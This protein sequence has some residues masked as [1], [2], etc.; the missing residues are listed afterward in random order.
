MLP[1]TTETVDSEIA[2]LQ[3]QNRAKSEEQPT[4]LAPGRL[5]MQREYFIKT[6]SIVGIIL[7]VVGI[8]SL[9][10]YVDPIRLMLRD[11][12]PHKTNPVPRILAGLAL[13]GGIALLYA[14]RGRD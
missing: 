10:Y 3:D 4:K 2:K 8:V 13:A 12:E 11:F 5:R 7:V 6:A 1:S 14:T 9:A